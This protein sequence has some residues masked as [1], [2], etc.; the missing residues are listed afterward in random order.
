MTS[1]PSDPLRSTATPSG[2]RVIR[3]DQ[4]TVGRFHWPAAPAVERFCPTTAPLRPTDCATLVNGL[5][6]GGAIDLQSG[7]RRAC[8]TSPFYFFVDVSM[9]RLIRRLGC[10]LLGCCLLFSGLAWN[11]AGADDGQM[12]L[13]V[14]EDFE[15]DPHATRWQP[16][17]PSKW[18]VEETEQGNHAYHLLG[19]SDYQPPYRSPH[20]I[21]LLKDLTVGDFELT[22]RVKTLQTSRGH[23]DM[24]VIFGYQDPAHF[25]YVHLGERTDDHANQIFVVDDAPRIK[26]SEQTNAGTPWKDDTWHRVRIVR[27]ADDGLIEVYFDDMTKPQMVAHDKRFAWGQI[28]LGS[29]DDMGLWDDVEIRGRVATTDRAQPNATDTGMTADPKTLEF[30]KWSGDVN[31]PDPVAISL[32]PH[33]RAYVTQT[34]RRKV[35]DLDIRENRDW[36][37]DDVGFQTVEDKRRFYRQQLPIGGDDA[38][39]AKRVADLNGDGAHDW[40]DLTVLSEKIHLVEDTDGDG[41]ADSIEL[42]ADGFQTEVTGIAAGVLWKDGDVYATIAPDVWRLR[43]TDGDGRADQRESIAHGFGLHIAYAGHDMHGLTVGPDGKIYWSIGDK[44]ISVTTPTGEQFLYPN[45]GGV[46]RC[47]PDGSDF[48][49]FAHGLRNVQEI[50][51]DAE[52]NLFGVDNDSDGPGEKERFVF[53]VPEMD[54]GWRCNFQYMSDGYSPWRNEELW[55]PESEKTPAYITPPIRNYIDGPA[56][57]AFNP[58]TALSP[59]YRDY[60]FLTGAPNGFQYAFRAEPDGASFRMV[61]DHLIGQ[62]I[63]LVGINFGPDGALY[64]VDW[65]G[66]YPLT[67]SGAVWKIDVPQ[68]S[69]SRQRIGVQQLLE[70]DF[71]QTDDNGLLG[72]LGHADQRVRLEAQFELVR[73]GQTTAL[74]DA[75]ADDSQGEMART[76]SIWGLGQLARDGDA[77]AHRTLT[78]LL[79]DSSAAIRLQVARTARDLKSFNGRRLIALMA[80]SNPQV[81]FQ[82]ALAAA[83]HPTPQLFDAAVELLAQDAAEDAYLRHAGIT[84]LTASDAVSGSDIAARLSDHPSPIVRQAAVVALRRRSDPAV[85]VF[86]GDS[87]EAVVAEA[88]RAIHDDWSIDEAMPALAMWL[89]EPRGASEVILRRSINANLRLGGAQQAERV[90][91]FAAREDQSAPMRA[92]ALRALAA[93]SYPPLLDRVDGRRRELDTSSRSFRADVLK[94]LLTSVLNQG[95]ENLP[96]LAVTAM[97]ALRI[98]IDVPALRQIVAQETLP[99]ELRVEALRALA[100]EDAEEVLRAIDEA[101]AS[102]SSELRKAALEML[103]ERSARAATTVAVEWLRISDSE[104]SERQLAMQLLGKLP[105]PAANERLVEELLRLSDGQSD[106]SLRLE[107]IT[108]ARAKAADDPSIAEALRQYEQRRTPTA[109]TPALAEFEASLWGGDAEAGERLFRQHLAAQCVRCHKIGGE[110]SDV[111]PDLKG[112]ATRRDREYLLRSV[113]DPSADIEPKYL[114]RTFLLASGQVVQG[115]VQS[116][117]EEEIVLVDNRGQEVRVL[118]DEIEDEREQRASI[119]P[120]MTDLMTP[121]EIRDVVAF[122]AQLQ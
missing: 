105:T 59:A 26:I 102:E 82:S 1:V 110:G 2:L 53:I 10:W 63:P 104:T 9:T 113:V 88:A 92:E 45:Q 114:S 71:Q 90:A 42:F 100:D 27:R 121:E 115:V 54:A 109:L 52:G 118:Q 32:D 107:L 106:P 37:P 62:G 39:A 122:L 73:R 112:I 41:T 79:D 56:G 38:A 91:R 84:A 46:L 65:G 49:V 15:S 21:S 33:G 13:L 17:D 116:E 31:V 6:D 66:G 23:R 47:N 18:R 14:H 4:C 74:R 95:T 78:A 69:E 68:F 97:R 57:F 12:P 119:M 43:D 11:A 61:D 48:E 36:I 64:G 28:G 98:K 86:L 50:A 101:L 117:T 19:Q 3:F 5:R 120:T 99:E 22:A 24:C 70:E 103:A 25:Y 30:T 111:G 80:D 108:A 40:R 85:A 20:S 76:H 35:Q 29:F 16:T 8:V 34:L 83:R 93:W 58:G 60:F 94:D 72:L 96:A 67:Q 89:D 87:A 81:R 55:K 75:A 7:G 44:G 77:L 51:F